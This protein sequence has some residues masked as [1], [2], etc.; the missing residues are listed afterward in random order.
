ML[1]LG[2]TPSAV[3]KGRL[4]AAACNDA[5]ASQ[6]VSQSASQSGAYCGT[7]ICLAA[8]RAHSAAH[9]NLGKNQSTRNSHLPAKISCAA[10]AATAAAAK[11]PHLPVVSCSVDG[12]RTAMLSLN[13]T[14]ASSPPDA[15]QGSP[16]LHTR[17]KTNTHPQRSK[18]QVTPE[19]T[20]S[21][22]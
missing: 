17:T 4:S 22:I 20:R 2:S 8:T 12:T 14:M 9:P 1:S 21:L 6:A 10:A 13:S 3:Q 15:T 19:C 7:S 11:H 18:A 16:Q 5:A